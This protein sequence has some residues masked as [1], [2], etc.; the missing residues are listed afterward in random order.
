MVL[1]AAS[2]GSKAG[3]GSFAPLLDSLFLTPEGSAPDFPLCSLPC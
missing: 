2:T 1:E 3:A